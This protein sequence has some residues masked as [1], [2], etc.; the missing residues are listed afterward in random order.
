MP[1]LRD[2]LKVNMVD[3]EILLFLYPSNRTTNEISTYMQNSKNTVWT[4]MWR[5]KK[6]GLV[7]FTETKVSSREIRKIY[8]LTA[9]GREFIERLK[10]LLE[11]E[12][13]TE[14]VSVDLIIDYKKWKNRS[15]K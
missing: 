10:A 6:R 8:S 9:K 2:E 4:T 3:L 13:P 12:V 15:K 7:E 11:K 14:A 5:M 1:F